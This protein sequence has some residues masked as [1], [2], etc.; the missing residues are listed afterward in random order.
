MDEDEEEI[1]KMKRLKNGQYFWMSV[2]RKFDIVVFKIK[3][4]VMEQLKEPEYMTDLFA[5]EMLVLE[6]LSALSKRLLQFLKDK[7]HHQEKMIEYSSLS[8]SGI[9]GTTTYSSS[10]TSSS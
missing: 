5:K 10:P 7:S 9:F 2:N 1:L 6:Y 4:F 8:P 3:K